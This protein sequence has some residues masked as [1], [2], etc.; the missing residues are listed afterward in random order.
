MVG[1]EA[2]GCYPGAVILN[3]GASP[4]TEDLPMWKKVRVVL[5]PL[6]PVGIG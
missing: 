6:K 4:R 5:S 3:V 2:D 1:L